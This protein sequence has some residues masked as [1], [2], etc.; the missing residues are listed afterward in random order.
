MIVDQ[1]P[2][3]ADGAVITTTY[4]S[5]SAPTPGTTQTIANSATP[6]VAE[7]LQYCANLEGVVN[8]LQAALIAHGLMADA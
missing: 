7:L 3:A 1:R 2:G 8:S 4:T 6:T 5:G